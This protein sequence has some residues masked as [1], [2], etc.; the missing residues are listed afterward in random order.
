[1]ST[2]RASRRAAVS[3]TA[4]SRVRS[5][6]RVGGDNPGRA[7]EHPPS[8]PV[9]RGPPRTMALLQVLL[10]LSAASCSL[11]DARTATARHMEATLCGVGNGGASGR[12]IDRRP[13]LPFGS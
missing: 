12:V 10:G 5:T 6:A 4:N 3:V 9:G 7:R 1:M 8:L 11:P 2:A 13:D